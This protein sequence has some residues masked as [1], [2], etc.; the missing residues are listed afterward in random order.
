MRLLKRISNEVVLTKMVVS[1]KR[2]R[3]LTC[4][5]SRCVVLMILIVFYP[6]PPGPG[7]EGRGK[8]NTDPNTSMLT[9][10]Q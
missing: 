8:D 9:H 10:T 1:N 3:A 4:V 5:V 6:N 7:D 2:R